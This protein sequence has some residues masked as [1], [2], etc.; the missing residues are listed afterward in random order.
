MAP[1]IKFLVAA[2]VTIVTGQEADLSLIFCHLEKPLLSGPKNILRFQITMS[3]IIS[4][5]EGQEAKQVFGKF[6]HHPRGQ[7]FT[8]SWQWGQF[9]PTIESAFYKI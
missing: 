3:V 4:M 5:Q 8:Q 2:I 7:T 9:P 6:Y 1:L